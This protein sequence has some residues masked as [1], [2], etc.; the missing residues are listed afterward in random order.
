[1]FLQIAPSMFV[2]VVCG[3]LV[4]SMCIDAAQAQT[5]NRLSEA[6]LK[7]L[8]EM[9]CSEAEQQRDWIAQVAPP[10]SDDPKKTAR[11]E[12]LRLRAG[13]LALRLERVSALYRTGSRG[14]SATELGTVGRL[15]WVAVADFAEAVGDSGEEAA[16]LR[17][18][19]EFADWH[20]SNVSQADVPDAAADAQALDAAFQ[21]KA[22]L[23]ALVGPEGDASVNKKRQVAE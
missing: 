19:V 2:S 5:S 10:K 4:C 18:A 11:A 9:V 14:G 8:A 15:A 23:A 3:S 21:L 20:A 22:R 12:I 7:A 16:C 13:A 6:S 17:R 1:M